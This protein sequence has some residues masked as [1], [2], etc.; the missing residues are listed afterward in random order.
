[1]TNQTQNQES[2]S[3]VQQQP[4]TGVVKPFLRQQQP[5]Q[6]PMQ[7]QQPL[8]QQPQQNQGL[9]QS[10]PPPPAQQQQWLTYQDPGGTILYPSDW[11]F[12]PNYGKFSAPAE[13]FSDKYINAAVFTHSD[14]LPSQS[15][16]LQ[17]LT[18]Y[19]LK[20]YSPES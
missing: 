14:S 10:Y 1:M 8:Q 11:I 2:S 5:S 12:D 7:Q 6:P 18:E 17:A 19:K 15:N 13:T 3:L 20:E 16:T 4:N 9:A